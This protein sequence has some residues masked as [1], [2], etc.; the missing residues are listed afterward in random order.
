[1]KV[2]LVLLRSCELT[3][4]GWSRCLV[5]D[6]STGLVESSLGHYGKLISLI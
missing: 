6:V 1:M 4:R 3:K 5:I 2:L